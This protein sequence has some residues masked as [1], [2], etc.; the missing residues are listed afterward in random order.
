V[1]LLATT[2]TP[3]THN[4][5]RVDPRGKSWNRLRASIGQPRF[6]NGAATDMAQ[7]PP[8]SA[9]AKPAAGAGAGAGASAAVPMAK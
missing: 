8:P 2:T 4:R 5:R 6:I 9:A 7:P 3:H 1:H